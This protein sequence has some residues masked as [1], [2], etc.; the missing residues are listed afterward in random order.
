MIYILLLLNDVENERS[1]IIEKLICRTN[2]LLYWKMA[3]KFID[4]V[5]WTTITL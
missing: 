2:V 4:F 5:Y 3:I 1:V